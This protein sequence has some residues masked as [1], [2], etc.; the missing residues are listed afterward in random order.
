MRIFGHKCAECASKQNAPDFAPDRPGWLETDA[1]AGLH[2]VTGP[3]GRVIWPG[4][5]GDLA[6]WAVKS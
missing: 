6:R 2:F 5:P 3:A 4:G 1:R